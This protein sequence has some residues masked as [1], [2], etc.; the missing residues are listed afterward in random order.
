LIEALFVAHGK[1]ANAARVAA[2]D[3]IAVANAAVHADFK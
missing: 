2:I 3:A 1:N